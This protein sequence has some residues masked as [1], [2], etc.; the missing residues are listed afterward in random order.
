M[1]AKYVTCSHEDRTQGLRVLLACRVQGSE[2]GQE[3]QAQWQPQFGAGLLHCSHDAVKEPGTRVFR[4]SEGGAGDVVRSNP[5][6]RRGGHT[7]SLPSVRRVWSGL[8]NDSVLNEHR[9]LIRLSTVDHM[10]SVYACA[11]IPSKLVSGSPL[12]GDFEVPL[13]MLV[14]YHTG[15]PEDLWNTPRETESVR[16]NL[17][18]ITRGVVST[19][20][21]LQQ[22]RWMH[23]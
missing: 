20:V 17:P 22:L 7:D 4:H 1:I 9:V 11:C 2:E 18:R 3:H 6:T 21:F 10:I 16:K 8:L 12:F 13:V 14:S 15:V 19:L 23:R 5:A